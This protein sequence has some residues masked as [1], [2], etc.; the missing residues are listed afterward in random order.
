MGNIRTPIANRR[1]KI[2]SAL[3]CFWLVMGKDAS[4][5][6]CEP[7]ILFWKVNV[8]EKWSISCI[9]DLLCLVFRGVSGEILAARAPICRSLRAL[10]ARSIPEKE[11]S[12]CLSCEQEVWAMFAR[13]LVS[14]YWLCNLYYLIPTGCLSLSLHVSSHCRKWDFQNEFVVFK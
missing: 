2:W 14:S 11:F 9:V 10:R 6:Y 5:K 4:E 7:R 3:F 1:R 13:F 12:R 8:G